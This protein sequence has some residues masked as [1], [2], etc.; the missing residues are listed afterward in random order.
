MSAAKLE[1]PAL[2]EIIYQ[3]DIWICNTGALSHSTNSKIGAGNIRYSG[4]ASIGHSEQAVKAENTINLAEQFVSRDGSLG[5]NTKL[6]DCNY[7]GKFNLKLLSL[8][9][10]L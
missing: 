10:L 3:N 1:M 4:S 7:N 9:R 8:T 6:S 5:I 2:F